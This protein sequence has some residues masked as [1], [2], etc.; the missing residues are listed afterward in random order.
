VF[1]PGRFNLRTPVVL[2][3]KVRRLLGTGGWINYGKGLKPDLRL[4]DGEAPVVFIEHFG[5]IHGGLQVDTRRTLVL[6]SVQ[7]CDL[8]FTDRARDAD[9]FLE[10][11]V[12]H[13]LR[14]RGGRT[15]ARQLNIENEGTHLVNDGGD[16]WI[17]GYKTERGG[18]L[19]ETRNRGRTEVLGNLSYTTTAG[20]L[21]PMLV[22]DH[23]SVFAFFQEVCYNGDPFATLVRETRNGQ[24]RQLQ[25]GEGT[26]LPFASPSP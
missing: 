26:L 18:T 4:A 2:R 20:K 5:N 24:T 12:T 25:R 1:L 13:H 8:T 15:W 9:L 16:L 3:G 11:V 17:L 21:A 23:A 19:L 10:D 22:I 14:L 7:D 6:R